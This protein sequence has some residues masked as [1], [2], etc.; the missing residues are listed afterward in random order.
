[1]ASN[2]PPPGSQITPLM[3]SGDEGC[4]PFGLEIAMIYLVL[5]SESFFNYFSD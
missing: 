5:H 4:P 3:N 2:W 1:M